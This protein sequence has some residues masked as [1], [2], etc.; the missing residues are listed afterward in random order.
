[1]FFVVCNLNTEQVN[2][3]SC[4]SR[5]EHYCG[6]TRKIFSEPIIR[7]N[8]NSRT[9]VLRQKISDYDRNQYTV[10]YWN[11]LSEGR[12]YCIGSRSGIIVMGHSYVYGHVRE[13]QC[14]PSSS[15]VSTIFHGKYIQCERLKYSQLRAP[16]RNN[17][18][19]NNT[20]MFNCY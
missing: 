13:I 11:I 8:R 1:M 19:F 9:V 20:F 5:T 10:V 6:M 3:C 15:C 4:E 16:R 12:Y 18:I 17:D 14:T 2:I 7:L